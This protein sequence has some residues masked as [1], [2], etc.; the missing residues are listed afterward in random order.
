M[1]NP[2]LIGIVGWKNS[3][4]TTLVA[5]LVEEFCARGLKVSAIKH[6]HNQ[7]DIDHKGRDSCHMRE[8]GAYQIALVSQR[9][10]ALMTELRGEEPP[11]LAQIIDSLD[12]CDLILVEG[13]KKEKHIKIE[14]RGEGAIKQQA[15]APSDPSI[16]AVVTQSGTAKDT[17]PC[18]NRIK[19]TQ[20]ADFIADKCELDLVP[21]K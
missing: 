3:G 16:I 5:R 19:V 2:R 6:A 18:F 4:K 20:I 10:C 8:A 13:Y 21:A 1:T 15:L 11:T 14:V 12:V 7:F 9:R 17:L